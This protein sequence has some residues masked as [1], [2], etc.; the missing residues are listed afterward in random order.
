MPRLSLANLISSKI[1][2]PSA[3]RKA[4]IV[5][6]RTP[7]ECFALFGQNFAVIFKHSEACAVSGYAYK[8]VS[9]FCSEE[10]SF[11]VHL[12]S[13]LDSRSASRFVEEQTG[14]CHKSPQVLAIRDGKLF[15]DASHEAITRSFLK[16]L[17]VAWNIAGR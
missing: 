5:E 3:I 1:R 10:A 7:A 15:A 12:L 11:K 13:V 2:V 6:V 9:Q 17:H 4:N 14:V 8:I 16:M